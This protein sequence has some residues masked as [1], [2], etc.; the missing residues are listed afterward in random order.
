M[1]NTNT[2][3]C[4]NQMT[5]WS[6]MFG[7]YSLNSNNGGAV[8]IPQMLAVQISQTQTKIIAKINLRDTKETNG[9]EKAA[10]ILFNLISKAI[11]YKEIF[12]K[13]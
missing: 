6:V 5:N 7:R 10:K 3:Q 9:L 8:S 2:N 12:G 11:L 4:G 13:G 1:T